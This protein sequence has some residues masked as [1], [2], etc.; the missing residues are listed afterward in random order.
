MRIE[1]FFPYKKKI[2]YMK[3]KEIRLFQKK[4]LQWINSKDSK[5]ESNY[6]NFPWRQTDD[7]YKLLI[8]EILLQKTN[9]EKV[10]EL[11]PI[12]FKN[13]P[14]I[15]DINNARKEEL[16]KILSSLGLQNEKAKR[17][18][19]ISEELIN[20]YNGIIPSDKIS[21]LKLKGVGN[22]IAN[23]VLCFAFNKKFEIVDTNIVRVYQRIFNLKSAK[24]RPRTDKKI[25]EFAKFMLP[26][27]YYRLF[28]YAL[29]DFGAQ[30]CKAK[31]PDCNICFFNIY[32]QYFSK[33]K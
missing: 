21:L 1:L 11:Y 33:F 26:D 8:T 10:A 14:S 16:I 29:L 25:W 7:H 23:A 17:L 19:I 3:N 30:I 9:S 13:F 6:R 28:N 5:N 12:F 22:Y 4:L 2:N 27:K 20:N 18:K 32:C 15:K 31:N 24:S